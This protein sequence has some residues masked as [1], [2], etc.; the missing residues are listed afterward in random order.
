MARPR[1]ARG[2]VLRKLSVRGP[3]GP[4]ARRSLAW[5]V[6]LVV[7]SQAAAAQGAPD[8]AALFARHCATCHGVDAAGVVGLAPPL[9]GEHWAR[10]GAEPSYLPTV[11]LHGLSGSIKVNGQLFVGSM[12]PFAGQLDD[13][14]LAAVANALRRL[15]GA[16]DGHA[17]QAAD[18]KALRGAAGS[19]PATRALR[20]KVLGG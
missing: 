12:P 11:M 10:L 5:A 17:Y 6:L 9:K 3:A 4:Q 14:A 7:L 16:A 20:L 13:E 2:A 18:F 19:P 8:G 15:Q 1:G